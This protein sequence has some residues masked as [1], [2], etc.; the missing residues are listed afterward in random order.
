MF[1][2]ILVAMD[3]SDLSQHACN[4]AVALAKAFDSNLVLLH[5]LSTDEE[6]SP[7]LPKFVGLNYYSELTEEV[8]SDYQE[9]WEKFV[10]QSLADLRSHTEAAKHAGVEANCTQTSGIPSHEICDFAK[11]WGAD[12]IIMGSHG[13][14][15]WGELFLGSVS[16]YVT[17]HAPCSVLIVHAQ[18]NPK[19]PDAKKNSEALATVES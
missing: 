8:W 15:G 3:N 11:T 1:Q 16:N 18:A 10:A 7:Q 5:V 17:H 2:K 14:S 19:Q 4:E 6:G 12:L 13:R 9:Q